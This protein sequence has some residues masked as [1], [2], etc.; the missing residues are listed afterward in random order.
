MHIKE[1]DI[2]SSN[3]LAVKHKRGPSVMIINICG[4]LLRAAWHELK[5]R[6]IF[7]HPCN[8]ARGRY[9]V[10]I[11]SSINTIYW[12]V[13]KSKIAMSVSKDTFSHWIFIT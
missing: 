4:D 12:N 1:D 7:S 6:R 11:M 8:T 13:L 2:T 3:L 9:T 5:P 10:G